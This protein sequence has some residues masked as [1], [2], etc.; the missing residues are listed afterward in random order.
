MNTLQKIRL[1]II[2]NPI[3]F[4]RGILFLTFI[5]HGFVSLGYSPGYTLHYRIFEAVNFFQWPVETFLK[6][7]GSW[8]LILAIG[9]ILGIFPRV[10]LSLA[11]VYLFTVAIA[12]F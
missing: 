5:G 6:I 3:L 10:F 7:Q 8:D 12:G 2:S 9:I 11:I 4:F 1:K